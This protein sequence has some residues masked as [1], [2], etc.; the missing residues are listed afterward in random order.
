VHIKPD[1]VEIDFGIAEGRTLA[2]L[3]VSLPREVAAFRL[4]PAGHPLPDGEAPRSAAGRGAGPLLRLAGAH[5]GRRV[6]VVAHN[7]LF[8]LSLCRLLGI[9][10]SDYRRVFPA[11]LNCAVTEV[12]VAAGQVSLMSYNVPTSPAGRSRHGEAVASAV[13]RSRNVAA[14]RSRRV[15]L[16]GDPSA[17]E[18]PAVEVR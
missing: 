9:P 15:R 10:Q 14:I 13:T 2:E 5:R 3:E 7:T 12:R 18:R 6:L 4:D 11:M 17:K 1:L 16:G 8:R